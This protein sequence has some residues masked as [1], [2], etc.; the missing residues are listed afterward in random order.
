MPH[1]GG[2]PRLFAF[3]AEGKKW[4]EFSPVIKTLFWQLSSEHIF[5]LT[6]CSSDNCQQW[7]LSVSVLLRVNLPKGNRAQN[8]SLTWGVNPCPLSLKL[9]K[10]L[11]LV[12]LYELFNKKDIC[13]IYAVSYA[14]LLILQMIVPWLS[15]WPSDF[16]TLGNKYADKQFWH[17]DLLMCL[18]SVIW[19][20]LTTHRGWITKDKSM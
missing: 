9:I 3:C 2:L 6:T 20:E 7:D 12:P 17:S 8:I 13:E 18:R 11:A 19:K 4:L 5:F 10:V 1:W 15:C 14:W 16:N